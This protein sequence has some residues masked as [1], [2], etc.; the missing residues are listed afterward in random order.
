MD[1]SSIIVQCEDKSSFLFTLIWGA[2]IPLFVAYVGSAAYTFQRRRADMSTI[3]EAL[4]DI[5]ALTRL[6]L[7]KVS[8]GQ[9]DLEEVRNH[10][11]DL[12][13]RARLELLHR[14]EDIQKQIRVLI[15]EVL[16]NADVADGKRQDTPKAIL[17]RSHNAENGLI[18]LLRQLTVI[19]A[20]RQAWSNP[21]LNVSLD[22]RTDRF[23][24]PQKKDEG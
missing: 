9:A 10:A 19:E 4:K 8:G 14:P 16:K 18:N 1:P 5:R 22:A 13:S 15:E 21:G 23:V 2:A 12:V 24:G 20:L 6:A 11:L 17:E 3:L 7:D